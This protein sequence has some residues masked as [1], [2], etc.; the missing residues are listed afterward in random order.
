M[1][2]LIDLG[3]PIAALSSALESMG[4]TGVGVD[5]GEAVRGGLR[6]RSFTVSTSNVQ[7]RR[8]FDEITELIRGAAI[9]PRARALSLSMLERLAEVEARLHG[10]DLQDVEFHELGAYD[11]IADLLGVAMALEYFD[12]TQVFVSPIET[13][14]G[15]IRTS[16]GILSVPAPGTLELLR[17][18]EITVTVPGFE[19]CTPT[20]AAIL[21]GIDAAPLSQ[22]GTFVV[23]ETGYGAGSTDLTDRPNILVAALITADS[24][25]RARESVVLLETNL[26]DRSGEF[27]A[28]SLRLLLS[29]GALDVWATPI[30][31][32][33]GR[34]GVVLSVLCRADN[35]DE[36]LETLCAS[37]GTLGVRISP[38][39]RVALE[40]RV[41]EID[42]RGKIFRVKVGPHASKIEFDDLVAGAKQFGE[43]ILGVAQA[44]AS[45]FV[46]EHPDL[47]MPL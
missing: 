12:V 47:P 22:A 21:A 11:T 44:V 34:P 24:S 45:R 8:R 9:A 5:S 35:Q 46:L 18:L 10:C 33:K 32:K 16:H 38:L 30:L 23:T 15:R 6:G 4:L 42:Y 26:D 14:L 19:L 43:P 13:G 7:P 3:F 27:V 31:A 37:T 29:M 2:A 1:A 39:G 28:E 41:V 25:L 36:L 17:G 20:G 40:R